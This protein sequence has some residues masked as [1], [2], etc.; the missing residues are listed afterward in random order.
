M[1]LII[2]SLAL[3][4]ALVALWLVTNSLKKVESLGD[5]ILQRV[6]SEQRNASDEANAKIAKLEKQNLQIAKKLE[7]LTKEEN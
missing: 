3:C 2:G 1:A 6:R 7:S 5:I 4:V